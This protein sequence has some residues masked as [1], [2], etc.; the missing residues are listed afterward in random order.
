MMDA[1]EAELKRRIARQVPY[2]RELGAR[3]LE[4]Y[5][6]AGILEAIPNNSWP[7]ADAL[8]K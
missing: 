8:F 3:T 6:K 5:A 1:D 2:L 7:V 4:A